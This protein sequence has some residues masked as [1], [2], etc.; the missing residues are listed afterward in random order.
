M[1][2]QKKFKICMGKTVS[3]LEEVIEKTVHVHE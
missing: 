2:K 3:L 1:S